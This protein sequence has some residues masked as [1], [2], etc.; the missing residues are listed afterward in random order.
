MKFDE[1]DI[2]M[3]ERQV[4]SMSSSFRYFSLTGDPREKLGRNRIQA[5]YEMVH[6]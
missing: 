5:I 1:K 4:T 2:F 3:I 6:A